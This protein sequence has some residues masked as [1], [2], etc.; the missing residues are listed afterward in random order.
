MAGTLPIGVYFKLPG[1]WLSVPPDEVGAHTSA[2]YALHPRSVEDEFTANITIRG[3]LWQ[4]PAEL[5]EI[6]DVAVRGLR[7]GPNLAHV[8]VVERRELTIQAVPEVGSPEVRGLVQVV[9]AN[10]RQDGTELRLLQT[11]VFLP[12]PYPRD[13]SQQAVIH[14]CLTTT[15]AQYEKLAGDFQF[16][17]NSIAERTLG[18]KFFGRL[19]SVDLDEVTGTANAAA[20]AV[21]D[22]AATASEWAAIGWDNIAESNGGS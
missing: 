10:R 20:D 2:F 4:S 1:G 14:I 7:E 13:P 22:L 12:A 16:F 6:A 8:D 19:G 9:R 11:Q 15:A 5:G 3:G 21:R 17:V 18:A